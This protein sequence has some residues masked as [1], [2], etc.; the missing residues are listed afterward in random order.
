[1]YRIR[2]GNVVVHICCWYLLNAL[3]FDVNVIVLTINV[4]LIVELVTF[5]LAVESI[6]TLLLMKTNSVRH[7]YIT[8]IIRV[9]FSWRRYRL[10]LSN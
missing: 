3:S 2:A 6:T 4:I 5:T 9:G 7:K 1:M 8:D 10:L